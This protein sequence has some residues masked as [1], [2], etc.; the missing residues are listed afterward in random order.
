M[1]TF[2]R[3][4]IAI[5]LFA[6]CAKDPGSDKPKA[7]ATTPVA[8]ASP[9]SGKVYV[10]GPGDSRIA[11]TGA[12]ITAAHDGT[13]DRFTGTLTV[14]DTGVDHGAVTVQ[15][16]VDSLQIEPAH[17]LGHLKTKDFFDVASY[18]T[19][20]FT[21]TGIAKRGEG[22]YDVT[23]NLALHG[24]TKSITFPATIALT[25]DGVTASAEFAINR[26]DFAI[27]YPG[28]PD[29]LIKDNVAIHLTIKAAPR[30]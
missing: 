10:F 5:A 15:I 18:P 9:V 3:S 6:G 17:L 23:G 27:V 21:S 12:K 2:G 20:T 22:H 1:E 16:D 24:V 30:S 14:P 4:L 13:F 8:T 26:K 11:F 7:L 25:G 28:K 19:A 29:D